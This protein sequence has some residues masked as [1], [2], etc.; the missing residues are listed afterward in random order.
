MIPVLSLAA[1][2]NDVCPWTGKPVSAEALTLYK[3][4]VIG[5]ADRASRDAF[6]SAIVAFETAI[7]PPPGIRSCTRP[8]PADRCAA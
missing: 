1:C 2:V 8:L 5:F 7:Q 3:G 4:R 6:L